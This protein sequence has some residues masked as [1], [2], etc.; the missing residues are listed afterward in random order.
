MIRYKS[1]IQLSFEENTMFW[2][3]VTLHGVLQPCADPFISFYFTS[4][5]GHHR[6]CAVS[7]VVP[8]H[9]FANQL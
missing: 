6:S 5:F 2:D 7:T 4:Q 3:E 8:V 1:I 9:P